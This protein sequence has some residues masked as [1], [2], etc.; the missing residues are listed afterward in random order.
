MITKKISIILPTYCPDQEVE[1]ALRKFLADLECYTAPSNYQLVVIE[2]GKQVFKEVCPP[3]MRM[4][5]RPWNIYIHKNDPI[6]YA[7]AVNLGVAV[8]EGEVL[9]VANNDLELA[10]HWLNLLD[11]DYQTIFQGSGLLSAMDHDTHQQGIRENESWYSLFM[12]SRKTWQTIGYFDEILNYRFHDQDYSIKLKK[13]GFRLGRTNNVIV[14]HKDSTTFKKMGID[15]SGEKE[16]MMKRHGAI[17]FSEW[18]KN[19]EKI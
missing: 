1:D 8:A 6:G 9:V 10:N 11:H 13:A 4:E 14:K 12:I 7:R 17:L 3:A 19:N 5:N 16:I 18:F 2:Q 15:E